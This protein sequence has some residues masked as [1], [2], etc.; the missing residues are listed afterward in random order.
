MKINFIELNEK[1]DMIVY[2]FVC[3]FLWVFDF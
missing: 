2:R 3:C 1:I